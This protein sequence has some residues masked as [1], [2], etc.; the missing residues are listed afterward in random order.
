[1]CQQDIIQTTLRDKSYSNQKAPEFVYS[2]QYQSAILICMNNSTMYRTSIELNY[3]KTQ[4]YLVLTQL[5][6]VE[7]DPTNN[8]LNSNN[9]KYYKIGLQ[10]TSHL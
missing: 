8:L 2:K 5:L 9:N 3:L 10:Y 4:C 1:M 7:K 6:P